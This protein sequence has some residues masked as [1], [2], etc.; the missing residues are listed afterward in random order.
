MVLSDIEV[1][2]S[3]K[4]MRPWTCFSRSVLIRNLFTPIMHLRFSP[5]SVVLE[6]MLLTTRFLFVLLILPCLP[7]PFPPS[8]MAPL[9]IVPPVS[10][11]SI[12]AM[13]LSFMLL[14]GHAQTR[15]VYA[16]CVVREQRRSYSPPAIRHTFSFLSVQ[17]LSSPNGKV[18][19]E[20]STSWNETLV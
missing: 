13:L 18:I 8:L 2:L 6:D 11:K 19:I 4:D 15:R 3:V 5:A 12:S 10:K 20:D 7:H 9:S 14:W 1:L 16:K 17:P